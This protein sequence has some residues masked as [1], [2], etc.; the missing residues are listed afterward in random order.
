MPSR[1]NKVRS[2]LQRTCETVCLATMVC[3]FGFFV[4]HEANESNVHRSM[5]SIAA[6][7]LRVL[8]HMEEGGRCVLHAARENPRYNERT[9]HLDFFA[10]FH[11]RQSPRLCPRPKISRER[12]TL[13]H[14]SHPTH[15]HS[16]RS[17]PRDNRARHCE[18]R[19]REKNSNF[20]LCTAARCLG[21]GRYR[22]S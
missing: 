12:S 8:G 19:F 9:I 17:R 22:K 16:S 20:F 13:G 7:S 1:I 21:S 2:A 5:L 4:I 11:F 18:N 3:S 10:S 14:D 15:A 6:R